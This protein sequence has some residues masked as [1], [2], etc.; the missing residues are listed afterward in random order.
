[1]RQA[2]ADHIRRTFDVPATPGNVYLTAGAAAALAISISA[3]TEPGDEVM[4]IS[5]FLPE[6]AVWVAT[7]GCTLVEEVLIS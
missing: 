3:I 5:P 1:M 6:Y 7:A 2:V 4:V